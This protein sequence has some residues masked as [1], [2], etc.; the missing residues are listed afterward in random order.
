MPVSTCFIWLL[1][2][3]AWPLS[4]LAKTAPLLDKSAAE[5]AVNPAV[6]KTIETTISR[7]EWLAKLTRIAPPIICQR[8]FVK[9]SSNQTLNQL[10]VDYNQCIDW[11][12]ESVTTCQKQYYLTIPVMLT[13]AD[14]ITWSQRLGECI[15]QDFATKHLVE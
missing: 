13:T 14:K 10:N 11:L 9:P 3:F 1:V 6:F 12:P 5:T 15:G 2:S 4:L 7:D 8:L